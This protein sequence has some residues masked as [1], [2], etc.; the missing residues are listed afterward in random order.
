MHRRPNS[1]KLS[2]DQALFIVLIGLPILAYIIASIAFVYVSLDFKNE[3]FIRSI[4][5]FF[6]KFYMAIV[7]KSDVQIGHR[8]LFVTFALTISFLLQVIFL[9]VLAFVD[10]RNRLTMA[11]FTPSAFFASAVFGALL[12]SLFYFPDSYLNI[13]NRTARAFL[14]TDLKYFYVAAVLGFNSFTPYVFLRLFA[15]LISRH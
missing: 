2:R 8:F 10:H 3:I 13:D 4:A 1:I 7:E 11:G 12:I 15:S 14:S 6:D 5:P 9:A